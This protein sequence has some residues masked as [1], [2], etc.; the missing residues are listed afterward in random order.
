MTLATSTFK[1][2]REEAL[3]ARKKKYAE[4]YNLQVTTTKEI[5]EALKSTSLLAGKLYGQWLIC[6]Y[7]GK[8]KDCCTIGRA[9]QKEAQAQRRCGPR[10]ELGLRAGD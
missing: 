1:K 7:S 2:F 6:I 5:A 10:S 4:Q 9:R 3:I 8:R